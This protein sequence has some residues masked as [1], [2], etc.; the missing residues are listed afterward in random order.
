VWR[1]EGTAPHK[2]QQGILWLAGFE[3]LSPGEISWVRIA[4]PIYLKQWEAGQAVKLAG[5]T[6]GCRT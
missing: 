2:P 1:S 6:G 5:I 3:N 4:R